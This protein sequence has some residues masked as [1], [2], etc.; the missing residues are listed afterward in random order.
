MKLKCKGCGGT[1]NIHPDGTWELNWEPGTSPYG[2]RYGHSSTK[3]CPFH[4]NKTPEQL[5]ANPMV[6]VLE[7]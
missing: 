5:K 4:Q 1:L 6:E 3:Q 2:G 7:E